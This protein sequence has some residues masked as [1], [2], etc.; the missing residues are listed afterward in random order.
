M[1]MPSQNKAEP[2]LKH[3]ADGWACGPGQTLRVS[4]AVKRL[5]LDLNPD[6]SGRTCP[7]SVP[8]SSVYS[9]RRESSAQHF[10]FPSLSPSEPLSVILPPH[11][12]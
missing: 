12:L 1:C 7:W 10:S 11:T 2:L 9:Q 6:A 4:G 8:F 3:L 5:L